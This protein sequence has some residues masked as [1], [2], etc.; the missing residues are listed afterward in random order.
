M[1]E[2]NAH[3]P[4]I[5]IDGSSWLYRA[6]HVLPPL[7]N[8]DGQPTGAIYGMTNMLRKFLREYESDRI[9]VVF[10]PRGPTF[11]NE[12]FPDYKAHRPP[13]PPDLADQFEGIR[14]V[15]HAMGLPI[16]QMD[17]VEADDVIGTL[18]ARE[19]GPVVIVTGDKDMAQLV[20]ERV[21]L[22]DTMQD[23]RTDV[24]RV[25]DKFGVGPELIT[26]YLALVGD[27]SDNIPGIEKVGPKTAAKWLIKYGNLAGVIEHADEIGGKVA[28]NLRARL[29]QLPLYQDLA[30]IRTELDLTGLADELTRREPDND[31]LHALFRRYDFSKFLE[32]L[33]TP[34]DVSAAP[35]TPAAPSETQYHTVLDIE[36]LEAMMAKLEAAELI[37]V[38]TETDALSAMQSNLVGLS[39][40]VEPGE[41]WYVPV[42][43]NYLGAPDQLPMD[44]VLD[45]V[46]GVLENPAISKLGQHIK[47][48]LNVLARYNVHV[49]GADQ[50]TMLESYVLDSTATRH[51]MDSLAQKYLE[52]KTTKF[53]DV[54]G[55]GAKQ[56]GFNQVSLDVATPYA[57]EDADI[58]LQ[59]HQ[60]LHAR[61]SEVGRLLEL[62]E[63]IEMPLMPVL[64]RVEANGVLVDDQLL[65]RVSGE[66]AERMKEIEKAAYD[67][68]GGE[69]NLGSPAQL[70]EILFDRLEL[71][72]IRK[73]PKGAPSTAED[74]L[75]ELADKHA[76]P[77]HIVAWRELS[78]LRSTYADKLPTLINP[79]TGRIHTSYHQAVAATGRLSSSD[80]NLQNIPI[81]TE[82]G[83]R[84]REAFI[85]P[86]GTKIL[87]VDYSQIE[88]RI[89]AHLSGDPGLLAAFNEQRDVH[90][91]TASEVF[92]TPLADVSP[93]QRR[94][95]K[96]INFGLMYGMSAYG[97]AK[98]LDLSREDAGAYINKFFDRFAGVA[99]FMDDT[100]AAAKAQ[101]YV[102][103]LFG[104]RLYL[105]EINA[106][107]A[108]RRQY[109]ERTAINAP[110]QGT[111][112]DLIKKAMIDVDAWLRDSA[113]EARMVM[114]VHDE[115]VFEVPAAEAEALGQTIAQRMSAVAELDV[116]LVAEAGVADNWQQAH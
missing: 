88:L 82:A 65:R 42:G 67:A 74:V 75:R 94:A 27:T 112:A 44:T 78:K 86:P 56:V 51:D 52:R 49:A 12:L 53:E 21:V 89:M 17:G 55:K 95:A 111:A 64:A 24:A 71:P 38:D 81:R 41:A 93:D 35:D 116:P 14:E 37:C 50:D 1:S 105:P 4:L 40:A 100:R 3:G 62:Y 115:L 59:L 28:D 104:R 85:A 5:L 26:D 30:T 31:A 2:S 90:A 113:V 33:D 7:T 73:T 70:K 92:D 15:I 47:Y 101:G 25:H 19:P 18:A 77:A 11:R 29:D 96:A 8:A 97:L 106:R 98:Q 43:H 91:A 48:D 87:A 46:R 45:R 57:A 9:V 32:E 102:E 114:Q 61:L 58:T 16:V 72:V 79:A 80:P 99:K 13:V 107:N 10:D 103:T 76:L 83:R 36:A 54:A 39:F 68:A 34:T 109:A 20:D 84:I 23:K 108:S 22:L 63:T 6:F 66:M 110:L 69:F 60:L